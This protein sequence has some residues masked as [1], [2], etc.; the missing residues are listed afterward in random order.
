MI[1][2]HHHKIN[3]V[4]ERENKFDLV[5]LEIRETAKP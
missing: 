3:Y 4:T 5:L 1:F 2:L